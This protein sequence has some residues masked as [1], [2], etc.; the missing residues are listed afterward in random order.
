MFRTS[1]VH[2]QE[3]YIVHEILYVMFFMRLCKQSGRWNDV[4]IMFFHAGRNSTQT[5]FQNEYSNS[6]PQITNIP[7]QDT[8]TGK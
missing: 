3:E 4:F 5:S 8:G 6:T 7:R 2:H 1:Y